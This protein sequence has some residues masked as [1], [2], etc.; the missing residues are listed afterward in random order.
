MGNVQQFLTAAPLLSCFPLAPVWI[1]HGCSSFRRY[2]PALVLGPCLSC[3]AYIC[4]TMVFSMGCG[5]ICTL[6]PGAIS[7]LLLLSSFSLFLSPPPL[8]VRLFLP[9][10]KK[11]FPRGAAIL[12]SGPSRAL[13]W[14]GWRQ[15]KQAVSSK[16][17]SQPLLTEATLQ[18]PADKSWTLEPHTTLQSST[19]PV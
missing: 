10:F 18:P 4:C 11:N 2:P 7:P 3:S 15:L 8:S 12:A 5:A 13:Q 19:D 16:G 1:L 14:G 17:Q 6:V 9:F